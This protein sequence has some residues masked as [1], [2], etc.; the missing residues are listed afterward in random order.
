MW[1]PAFTGNIRPSNPKITF[2]GNCF[3]ETTF[4]IIY[5]PDYPSEAT[6]RATTAKPRSWLCSDYYIFANAGMMH[7][8]HFFRQGT[9]DMKFIAASGD[10]FEA[11]GKILST[12]GIN[13]Y[14][15]CEHF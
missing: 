6:V 12:T 10:N 1:A 4:E 8:E 2:E 9:W 7:T 3:E 5:D 13:T 14:L 15:F 11:E